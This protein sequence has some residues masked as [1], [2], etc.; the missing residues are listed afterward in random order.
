MIHNLKKFIFKILILLR[1]QKR[2]T[3]IV[4][5]GPFLDWAQASAHSAGYASQVVLRKVLKATTEVL[6][7][8]VGFERDGTTFEEKPKNSKIDSILREILEDHSHVLDFGGGL[9]STFLNNRELIQSLHCN[10]SIIEQSNFV[11]EGQKLVIKYKLPITFL[12]NLRDLEEK[13]LDVVILSSV[14]QY[15]PSWKITLLEIVQLLPKYILI[16]RTPITRSE[17]QIFVQNNGSYYSEI[18]NYPCWK[19]NKKELV[20][21]LPGYKL[22]SDWKS[23]FDP[24]N[25]RGFMFVLSGA[26]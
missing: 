12:K 13:K 9:G 24:D 15:L 1:F 20:D 14:L 11:T 25:Y 2:G 8:K 6:D 4:Y 3:H 21:N 16:D 5:E 10:Y 17:S 26:T 7:G 22:V 19:I 18:L 23:G